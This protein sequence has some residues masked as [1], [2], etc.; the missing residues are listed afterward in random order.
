M[1][2]AAPVTV[3]RRA[4]A[5]GVIMVAGQKIALGRIHARQI[6]S[7]HVTAG[8]MTIEIGA[9]GIQ[10]VPAHHQ[11]AR[12]QPQSQRSRKAANVS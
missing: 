3:Q 4:S 6:V 1:P 9:G 10:T 11:Q 7:V 2:S 8:T 5:T 12:P